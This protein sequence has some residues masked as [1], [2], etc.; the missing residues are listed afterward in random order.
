M[1]CARLGLDE[2]DCVFVCVCMC[3]CVCVLLCA[4]RDSIYLIHSFFVLVFFVHGG[5][6]GDLQDLLLP[7]IST[8]N[9]PLQVAHRALQ[10]PT[11]ASWSLCDC[12]CT[13]SRSAPLKWE[14]VVHMRPIVSSLCVCLPWVM[15][16]E[17][18]SSTWK[19]VQVP[20]QTQS[21]LFWLSMEMDEPEGFTQER[22]MRS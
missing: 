1:L 9:V 6:G 4:E 12:V 8:E 21:Q 5:G 20:T 7:E 11:S 15:V 3:V 17:T 18:Q 13:P 16:S 19:L 2:T 10:P 14:A 22:M